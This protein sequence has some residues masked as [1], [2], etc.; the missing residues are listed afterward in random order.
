MKEETKLERA[1]QLHFFVRSRYHPRSDLQGDALQH[2]VEQI[3]YPAN[4]ATCSYDEEFA[5]A[6]F[7]TL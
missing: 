1:V 7:Q 3:P 2:H 5:S 6:L 4:K